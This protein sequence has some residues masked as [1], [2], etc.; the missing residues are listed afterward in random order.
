MIV[1]LRCICKAK[2]VEKSQALCY[3]NRNAPSQDRGCR[4]TED[5]D[6]FVEAAQSDSDRSTDTRMSQ[7]PAQFG[8]TPSEHRIS[9]LPSTIASIVILVITILSGSILRPL[10]PARLTVLVAVGVCGILYIAGFYW[11]VVPAQYYK[12]V[13]GWFNAFLTSLWIA[14]V[15]AAIPSQLDMYLGVLLILA[16]ISSAIF[17]ER[18]PSY[19]LILLSTTLI[20]FVRRAE[21]A[22]L[23][24]WTVYLSTALIAAIIVETFKQL[25]NQSRSHIRRLETITDFNRKITST[26]DTRQVMTL[27]NAAFQNAVEADTYFVGI[28][29]GNELRLE[30]IY[31][32]GEYFENLRVQLEGS[33]SSWVLAHHKSLFLPDLRKEVVLPG[34]RLVLLG[35]HKTNLS[36]MGV[37]MQN[38]IIDGIIAIGSYRPNAFDRAD[39]ELLTNLA[40]HAAQALYNSHEHAEVEL[41]SR[42]DSLTNVYNHGSF[43]K[44]LQEHADQALA[45]RQS[46][47]LIMLDVD[48][49]KGY[50]DSYGHL[51]G[52]EVL[53]AL[54][55]TIK[56][57][58]KSTD[59]VG[60]W[61]G[62]E[63]VI[64]LPNVDTARAEQVA[65]RVRDTMRTLTVR[66]HDNSTVPVPTVSQGV[67][68]FPQEADS[69]MELIHIADKRLYMA[70]E[71]GRNQIEPEPALRDPIPFQETD[72]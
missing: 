43:L 26:L 48:H 54:C 38:P 65:L 49:F 51:V 24:E 29:E 67:A 52:D 13:Y 35:K 14:A 8:F 11:I 69:V 25:K 2:K 15:T 61:G 3:A 19:F 55:Q 39:L 40:Q 22:G 1:H 68:V 57:H 28:R 32:D 47:S 6:N 18:G 10:S 9:A 56:Q 7:V 31:D 45:D 17:S 23:Q 44:M 5:R 37:P 64:C 30:L 71:R 12:P 46:M 58:I 62:E 70:K 27:L 21:L 16:V 34:V 41:R 4:S 60:R 72:T 36:W 42:L 20:L 33:L 63:F 59:F 66:V 50:N 53:I